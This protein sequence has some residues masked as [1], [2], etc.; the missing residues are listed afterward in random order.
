MLLSI[1]RNMK[2][3]K[4][5][6]FYKNKICNEHYESLIMGIDVYTVWFTNLFVT[7][8]NF[9]LFFNLLELHEYKTVVEF[10]L[11]IKP[12]QLSDVFYQCQKKKLK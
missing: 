3:L 8:Q 4:V 6:E 2:F 9:G 5:P 11:K 7:M 1:L 12:V 10:F